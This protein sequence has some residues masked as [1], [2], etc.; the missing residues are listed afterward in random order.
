MFFI[1][2]VPIVIEPGVRALDAEV[3]TGHT[4]K[5]QRK[6]PVQLSRI[7]MDEQAAQKLPFIPTTRLPHVFSVAADLDKSPALVVYDAA[8]RISVIYTKDKSQRAWERFDIADEHAG[9][10]ITQFSVRFVFNTAKDRTKFLTALE[11]ITVQ[12]RH[13]EQP[14]MEDVMAALRPLARI[15]VAPVLLPVAVEQC[16]MGRLKI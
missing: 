5:Y 15:R 6:I 16:R 12:A 1:K 9:K 14:D 3:V 8:G 11:K 2:N 7:E 13:E 10:S 4:P